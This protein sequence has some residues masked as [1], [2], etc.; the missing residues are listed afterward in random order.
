[1]KPRAM[2]WRTMNNEQKNPA[3]G[4]DKCRKIPYVCIDCPDG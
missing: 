4:L 2:V 1:M 3:H